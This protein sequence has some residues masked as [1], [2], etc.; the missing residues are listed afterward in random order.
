MCPLFRVRR[1]P[2]PCQ[3]ILKYLNLSQ[4]WILSIDLVAY[5]S[6][7]IFVNGTQDGCFASLLCFIIIIF[8][9]SFCKHTIVLVQV[10]TAAIAKW[11]LYQKSPYTTFCILSIKTGSLIKHIHGLIY[12]HSIYPIYT[13]NNHGLKYIRCNYDGQR[14][15]L[16]PVI[17]QSV[18]ECGWLRKRFAGTFS[19]T[20]V[21]QRFSKPLRPGW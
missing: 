1:G 6:K 16:H 14:P 7:P 4:H 21:D 18:C 8:S 13:S 17:D 3:D 15:H 10:T 20:S 12:I 2:W 9:V 11:V 19:F 5:W